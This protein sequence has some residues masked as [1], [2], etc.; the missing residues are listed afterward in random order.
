MRIGSVLDP[1]AEINVDDLASPE[2]RQFLVEGKHHL[3][4]LKAGLETLQAECQ[5]DVAKGELARTK[6]Q[7]SK[8]QKIE[9]RR[10]N[11]PRFTQR[12]KGLLQL[13]TSG[14]GKLSYAQIA[15]L[16]K[17][18]PKTVESAIRRARKRQGQE[19]SSH[20]M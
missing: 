6:R 8:I 7:L 9:A 20:Q 4:L 10:R 13:H 17:M 16:K 19:V 1:P 5:R 14:G 3:E 18:R 2:A 15:K 12:D 11:P